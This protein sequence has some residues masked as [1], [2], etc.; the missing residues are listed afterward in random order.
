MA[1]TIKSILLPAWPHSDIGSDGTG[2]WEKNTQI[3]DPGSAVDGQGEQADGKLLS[4][5]QHP[6][7]YD[8]GNHGGYGHKI[9]MSADGQSVAVIFNHNHDA[10]AWRHLPAPRG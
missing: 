7:L 3:T 2:A 9:S 4:E 6:T 10:D 1:A 8:G 5:G